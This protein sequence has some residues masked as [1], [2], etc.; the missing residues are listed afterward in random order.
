MS[1]AVV[2]DIANHNEMNEDETSFM[3]QSLQRNM[4]AIIFNGNDN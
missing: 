2:R 3:E 4:D 1:A